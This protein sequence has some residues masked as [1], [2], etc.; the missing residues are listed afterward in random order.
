MEVGFSKI[1]QVADSE[2]K[3]AVIVAA[4]EDKWIFV[5][6]K[7]R[8]TWEIPGGHRETGEDI[9]TAARRELF[10][11][12]GAVDFDIKPVED[13]YCLHTL[14][15]DRPSYGRLYYAEVKKLGKLPDSEIG[16]VKLF[17]ELPEELTYPEIQPKLHNK[18]LKF[19]SKI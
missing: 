11:E 2:L 1:G 13:Y 4:F 19:I 5:K 7:M 9:T 18:I 10:E 14:K 17:D 3:F 15:D 8:T 12:T 6:H 16:E